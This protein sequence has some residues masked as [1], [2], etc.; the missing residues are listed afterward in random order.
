MMKAYALYGALALGVSACNLPDTALFGPDAPEIT[1]GVGANGGTLPPSGGTGASGGS[2][3]QGG[4]AA[5]PSGGTDAGGTP[6]GG[7]DPGNGSAGEPPGAPGA[8]G[9][10]GAGPALPPEPPVP[11]CGNGVIET[12]EECDDAGQAGMDGCEQCQVIC[13]HFGAGT[14]ES[15]DHHCYAGYDEAAFE[16]AVAACEER[17]AHLVTIASAAENELVRQLVDNSKFIGAWEDVG[18]M[19][20]G[21]GTYSWIT[22]ERLDYTNWSQNE[23]DRDE[24]LCSDWGLQR[25]YEHCVTMDGQ[26]RWEDSSCE[27]SDG[28]VCEWEPAQSAK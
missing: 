21:T 28:Y 19:E 15:D 2:G 20:K 13:S 9:E 18:P 1:P 12:G 8:A 26:G 5:Q 17:G 11:Q 23:P 6:S 25:C 27:R 7:T 3:A 22:G 24:V 16:A 10:G 14:V 4:N